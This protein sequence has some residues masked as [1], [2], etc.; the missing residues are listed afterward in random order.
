VSYAKIVLPKDAQ[1]LLLEDSP[2]RQA[3]FAKRIPRLTI[4]E[5]VREMGLYFDGKP[6]CDFIFF[7]HD[8][9]EG[10]GDGV[11]ATQLVKSRFGDT[12][13]AGLIHSWN[14]VGA[15]RM[16][17]ILPRLLYIPFGTFELEVES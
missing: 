1:V 3:W 5:S 9:G 6:I 17:A 11:E 2:M 15:L 10:N 7:D 4:V 8:L 16:K 12:A 14:Q 13:N